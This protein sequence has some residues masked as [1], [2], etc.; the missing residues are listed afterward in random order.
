MHD[1]VIENGELP[2]YTGNERRVVIPDG[3]TSIG[4]NAFFTSF[5]NIGTINIKFRLSD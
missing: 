3:V 4:K 2:V 1:F 5:P